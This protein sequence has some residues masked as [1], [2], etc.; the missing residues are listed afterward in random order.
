MHF[1]SIEAVDDRVIGHIPGAG[2]S[3][4]RELA[5]LG[6]TLFFSASDGT[7]GRE[8]WSSDGTDPGTGR[9][10]DIRPGSDGSDPQELTAAGVSD[11]AIFLDEETLTL[12]AVQ[13]LADDHTSDALPQTAIVKKWWAYM[14]DI[15]EVNPDNS[16]VCAPLSEVFYMA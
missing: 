6:S 3:D 12:F 5:A 9:V 16:P 10:A 7:S 8:L 4:P 2:S 1:V 13:K 15:M 14:A 11:Y